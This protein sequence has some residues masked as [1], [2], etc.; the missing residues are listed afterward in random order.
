MSC[1]STKC[2]VCGASVPAC[3]LINGKCGVCRGKEAQEKE[4]HNSSPPQPVRKPIRV[5]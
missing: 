2:S 1:Q 4:Q 5:P 3:Q